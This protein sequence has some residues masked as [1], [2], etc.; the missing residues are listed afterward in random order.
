MW[1]RPGEEM[2]RNSSGASGGDE[3][4][5]MYIHGTTD[6]PYLEDFRDTCDWEAQPMSE[7]GLGHDGSRGWSK[8]EVSMVGGEAALPIRREVPGSGGRPFVDVILV[9]LGGEP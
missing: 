7:S 8:D 2:W 9:A 1:L 3:F 4:Q 5:G 6:H